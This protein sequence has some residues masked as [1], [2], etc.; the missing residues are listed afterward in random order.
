MESVSV[1]QDA[2]AYMIFMPADMD[3]Q[4]ALRQLDINPK[5]QDDVVYIGS[6]ISDGKVKLIAMGKRH[7]TTGKVEWGPAS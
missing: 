5:E 6:H 7:G 2:V 3:T 1:D 4:A